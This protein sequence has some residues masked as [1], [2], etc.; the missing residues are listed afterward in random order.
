[1]VHVHDPRVRWNVPAS[2][3]LR[4]VPAGEWRG[5]PAV[6]VLAALGSAPRR[7]TDSSRVL[8]VRGAGGREAALVTA[9]PITVVEVD[10]GEVLPL[11]AELAR[12]ALAISAI[13]VAADTSLSLLLDPLAIAT[14]D[15][16]LREEPCPSRS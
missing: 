2:L 5:A 10:A 8:I 6:D 9:G 14:P 7:G 3:V 12:T 15:A 11:P 13:I 16:V 4:I 1:M